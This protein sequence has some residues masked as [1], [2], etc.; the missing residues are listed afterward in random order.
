[1]VGVVL[2]WILLGLLALLLLLLLVP[3][4]VYAQVDKD[5]F[6]L[7]VWVLGIKIKLFPQKE[8]TPEQEEKRRVAREKRAARKKTRQEKKAQKRKVKEP[9]QKEP[10][11]PKKKTV[12]EQLYF[13]KK[14]ATSASA[15][16]KFMAKWLLIRDVAVIIPVQAEDAA[17]VALNT[18][19]LHALVG[20]VRAA[21][22]NVLNIRYKQIVIVPDFMGVY[23]DSISFSCKVM[24]SP[25]IIL[26][27]SIIG[28][29]KFLRYDKERRRVYLQYKAKQRAAAAQK[30]AAAK[31]APK[32]DVNGQY[33]KEE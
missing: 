11:E 32:A 16:M 18:G 4:I 12:E 9:E 27:A 28:F 5:D 17:D 21:L 20:G 25:V 15:G 10:E 1:M 13:I 30:K 6:V 7:A 23:G 31:T 8:R 26:V 22:E 33:K 14:I 29:K 2:L 24:A 19:R 3:V